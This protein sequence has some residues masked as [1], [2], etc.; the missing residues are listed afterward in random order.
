MSLKPNHLIFFGIPIITIVIMSTLLLGI[1]LYTEPDGLEEF[2][3]SSTSS[4]ETI[5]AKKSNTIKIKT[6]NYRTNITTKLIK[7][8]TETTTKITRILTTTTTTTTTTAMRLITTNL[9]SINHLVHYLSFNGSLKDEI[10]KK[11][12][13]TNK[14][15]VLFSFDKDGIK[16]NALKLI[17]TP[18][19]MIV[20]KGYF[21]NDFCISFWLKKI[22]NE[23]SFNYIQIIN[24]NFLTISIAYSKSIIDSSKSTIYFLYSKLNDDKFIN[25]SFAF[26]FDKH[27]N[28]FDKWCHTMLSCKKK[29][30]KVYIDGQRASNKTK[31]L[32][33]NSKKITIELD[34]IKLF[35]NTFKD[36]NDMFIDFGMPL[37]HSLKFYWPFDDHLMELK[38]S[39]ELYY[40]SD[41][42]AKGNFSFDRFNKPKSSL[43][44]NGKKLYKAWATKNIN[45]IKNNIENIFYFNDEMTITS[46]IYMISN[47]KNVFLLDFGYFNNFIRISIHLSENGSNKLCL[48][49]YNQNATD[50]YQITSK[51]KLELIKWHFIAITLSAFDN[52]SKI[53]IDGKIEGQIN[54]SL[55]SYPKPI[56]NHIGSSKYENDTKAN[57]LI[58]DLKF[59]H[60]VLTNQ[61]IYLLSNEK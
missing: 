18:V 57:F 43:H 16:N 34:E 55:P 44:I 40:G 24:F 13:I 20:D 19:N 8:G 14:N 53:Y 50:S 28:E 45:T 47:E 7:L 11:E 12:L 60:R 39:T 27:E 30:C 1:Y 41:H 6:S 15:K 3:E 59:Y 49:V 54:K 36:E 56:N 37:D 48:K 21:D 25:F 58:D 32:E 42:K 33:I 29:F 4:L 23:S 26:E 46:W 35:N 31:P 17:E 9:N 38:Q 5:D 10:T 52:I 61:E 51:N 22:A 2:S